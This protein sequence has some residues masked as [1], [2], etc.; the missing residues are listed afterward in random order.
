MVNSSLFNGTAL[1]Q[2]ADDSTSVYS[3]SLR[4]T[5]ADTT[6]QGIEFFYR[7]PTSPVSN[8]WT[9]SPAKLYYISL[10][11][12]RLT[13][14]WD[15]VNTYRRQRFI[16]GRPVTIPYIMSFE[17]YVAFKQNE[18]KRTNTYRLIEEG[19]KEAEE[20]RG[21]LDFK[22][23]V[24][25]GENSA[26]TSIFGKPEVNLRVNGSA[27]MNVGATIQNIA[28]DQLPKDQQRRVDPTFKQNLQLNIQG[29]IGDKLTISTDWNTERTFDFD[30]RLRIVYE[31]YEDEIIKQIEMGNVSMETG[32]SL[33]TGGA[34]LFGIKSIAELGPLKLT[35]VLSQQKGE[36]KSTTITG[37][38]EETTISIHPTDYEDNRH[39]FIDF[40]NRQQFEANVSNPQVLGQAYQ[41][42]DLKVWVSEPQ[43][44]TTAEDAFKAAAFTDLGVVEN[45]DGTYG[46]PDSENDSIDDNVLIENQG[47]RSASASDFNV[48]GSD[49]YNGYFR[50]LTEGTDYTVNKG[51][52]TITLRRSLTPGALLAVSF[53][54]SGT[55]SLVQ[56]GDINPRSTGLT[57]LK[58]IRPDNL[59]SENKAWPLT[60]RNVYSLGLSNLSPDGIEVSIEFTKGNV[61]QENLPGRNS[62][63]LADLGLDR[64]NTQ[65]ALSPDNRIDFTGIVLDAGSG[66]IMFPYLEPFGERINELAADESLVFSELYDESIYNAEQSEKNG[67]YQISGTSRGGSASTFPLGFTVVEGSVSIIANGTEL[68]EGV[69]Y[70]VDY[71]YGT[72]TILNK[73]YLAPGQELKIE[74]EDNQV[75][76]IGQKNF[77][78]LR[79]EYTISKDIKLGGTFFRLKEQ[80]PTDKIRVGNEP[81]NNT[82]IG[83]DAKAD[84]DTPWITRLIDKVPL[85][86]TKEPSNISISGELAQLRPGVAQTNAVRDAIDRNEL[87]QDEEQGLVFLDDFEAAEL[88]ISFENA[89]RWQLA[90]PPAAVPGYVPDQNYFDNPG[91]SPPNDLT[92]KK[93][94]ADLRAQFSWY[95]IPRN[96]GSIVS[97]VQGTPESQT[98]LVE[99]VFPGRETNNPQDEVIIPLDIYYNPNERGP[100]NYNE[101]LKNV[102]ENEPDRTWGG[103][104]T[105][106]PSGQQDLN[107][108]N[109]EFIEFWV[110]PVLPGGKDPSAQDIEDY[111]GKIYI[112]LGTISEDI[113]PNN[114]LNT[115]D[116]LANSLN[117]L[118][119]DTFGEDA[120][121][122]VPDIQ[123][124]PQ[125]EFSNEN[126]ELEDVGLDGVP[127]GNGF[128]GDKVETALFSDF[129]T[130]MAEQYGSNSSKYKQMEEDPSND[131]YVHYL[132]TRV[133]GL[134]LQQRFYRLLGYHEDNSPAATGDGTRAIT[135]RPDTEGLINQSN[136]E[137]SDSYYQ[138]EVN[139]NPADFS[140]LKIGSEG[141]FIVDKVPGDRQEDRWHL[142]RI[143]LSEYKRKVGDIQGFQNVSYI[144]VWMAG[145]KKPFTVRFATLKFVGSQWRKVVD[146][147]ETQGSAAEFQ[148]ST[149]NIEENANRSPIPYRQPEG[150]IRA[151]NRGV[152]SQSLANEQSIALETEGLAS[153]EIKMIKQVYT[154]ELNLL[155]Y[156]NMR[157][158]VHGEGYDKRGEAEL[159]V[160]FGTDLNSNYYEYR[161]PITPSDPNYNYSSYDPGS[162]GDLEGDAEQIWLYEDNSMNI[163][164]SALNELKQLRDQQGITDITQVYELP[165]T[166][167]E[168]TAPGAVIA[169]KG[170]PSLDR[171]SEIGMG[172]RNPHDPQAAEN[173]ASPHLNATVWLNELRLSGFD[174]EKG[175]KANAKAKIKL[176][177]FAS[178][179]TNLTKETTGFGSLDSRL[180]NRSQAD[181]EGYD[182][183]TTVNLH[184][185]IPDRFGWNFPVTFTK[186]RNES[187]PKFLP[188]QGDIRLK[189]FISATKNNEEFSEEQQQQI[190][191]SKVYDVQT[192]RESF[193]I[194]ASNISKKQSESKLAQYT[195]DNIQF[196]FVYN[197]G[198][199]R[200]PELEF[201]ENWN[202]T[203]GIQYNLRLRNVKLI[204]PFNFTKNIPIVRALAGLQIGYVP[205]TISASSTLK[206]SYD[207]K[208]SR[209]QVNELNEV[210]KQPLQQ[211]HIF[212]NSSSFGFNYNLT[213]SITT[214]FRTKT[215]LDLAQAGIRDLPGQT[216][217]DST[218]YGII[219]S[220]EALNNIVGGEQNARRS[221]YAENYTAGWRPRFNNIKPLS[222]L[223]YSAS[224]SGGYNW[225]NSPLGSNLG[226]TV[227][228]RMGLDNSFS[229]STDE[230]FEGIGFISKM[231]EADETESRARNNKAES[232]STSYN[233]FDNVKYVGRKLVLALFSMEEIDF[234]YSKEKTA[235]QAGYTGESQIFYS[236]ND[237]GEGNFSP[238]LGYRIGLHESLPEDQFIQSS[239]TNTNITISKANTYSDNITLGTSIDLF[240]NFS[241]ELDWANRWDERRSTQFNLAPD[242]SRT[243]SFTS[244]GNIN[245]SVWAFGDGYVQMLTKQ[246]EAANADLKDGIIDDKNGNSD[247]RT[248]LN[249][250]TL[251]ED[252]RSTYLFSGH[253]TIGKK[254][255]NPL[256]QPTWSVVW[257]GVEKVI[258]FFGRFMRRATLSHSY[259]GDY[260][261]GWKYNVQFGNEDQQTVGG[262]SIIDRFGK[263]DPSSVNVNQTFS[264]L[265]QLNITWL[266]DLSTKIGMTKSKLASF[267]PSSK[268][269]SETET[270]GLDFAFNYSFKKITIP[271]FPKIKN[272]I[273]MTITA[274]VAEDTKNTYYMANH[275]TR[276]FQL[277]EGGRIPTPAE[278]DPSEFTLDSDITGQQRIE[279]S[280][281]I[282]YRFSSTISANFE[283]RYLKLN[284]KASSRAP[285]TNHDILFNIKI[286][287]RSR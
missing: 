272:N 51:L 6:L 184:K 112:D 127:S 279:G 67:F 107:Q 121:S 15:S 187:T 144:R 90:A 102:L 22:I 206:R 152:Q 108:N 171:I 145:Y 19:K 126:R 3:D 258:P 104:T 44:G 237:I 274:K 26:F 2:V 156:S 24:P 85:L 281:V 240:K 10:G 142:V 193:S 231:M 247:G 155:N 204:R 280:A 163:V 230:I 63:L 83:L 261:V 241:I 234:N 267:S 31:G 277:A 50:P 116:G 285:R 59:V 213:P 209:A 197:E 282:G 12:D 269:L 99:D 158:F 133:G 212:N 95:E 16:G 138:Y 45:T 57:Y 78:G 229:I 276:L 75:G 132:D 4:G 242:G 164:L 123:S 159:V 265:I 8:W 201:K 151:L 114:L 17:E 143:P 203:A 111:D 141:T 232:D 56:V 47:N 251:E 119:K 146:L 32:N 52:G 270:Q 137:Q 207:E 205:S 36:S 53:V 284:P 178:I 87:F 160:R 79:A 98:V 177:D 225:I 195:L 101:Q 62:P 84:F 235:N 246:V 110:Q 150:S 134:P 255:F 130:A 210:N 283:Y 189:E 287:I 226:A 46:L 68:I 64:T 157:M 5:Q 198:S 13:T 40:Y 96:I 97:G 243:S 140:Q 81:I 49:F 191:D 42:Q 20:R 34:S 55:E 196:S 220:F 120:R 219:P 182:V 192:V 263:Y 43:V 250:R 170:N 103:M 9:I 77:T 25:G 73:Q 30:N 11:K 7:R 162:G 266:S 181:V 174:N 180:G 169:V 23:N 89:T 105:T 118:E 37:G 153:Q 28:D 117:N 115:E 172:I 286:A 124:P 200:N 166:Q 248:V 69:D 208:R 271:F 227:S 249:L 218:M 66:T 268:T 262:F 165:L 244:S 273:D 27:N 194:N 275:L 93:D 260:R 65:G 106:I 76:S 14:E 211:S 175:W 264:P 168:T 228:N 190:I 135:K 70:E 72:V 125:G 21:L 256:P 221:Q 148:V 39:F 257:S 109:I 131:D 252:F 35:S 215:N 38:S 222:W 176:A 253:N 179:N 136:I 29:T 239:G 41:I 1:G 88:N 48:S 80:P 154:Q 149:I 61:S 278:A 86:Q 82:V 259:K 224:Y 199:A 245:S 214:S 233:L 128:D 58:L 186:R 202:Y 236:F 94:R 183:S 33:I 188:N 54:R 216:G 223:E 71:S 167:D 74:S 60:M 113:V 238:P 100:Y 147:Q 185:L 217:V 139:L 91:V 129:L 161:Q 122:Y 254:G 18:N 92:S 173:T